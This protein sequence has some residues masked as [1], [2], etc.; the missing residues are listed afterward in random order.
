MR[1]QPAVNQAVVALR[2]HVKQSQQIFATRLGMSISTLQNH[3]QDTRPEPKQLLAFQREA[4]ASGRSDLAAR[5][6]HELVLS[7]ALNMEMDVFVTADAFE[8]QA[9]GMLLWAI[10][11]PLIPARAKLARALVKEIAA[12]LQADKPDEAEEFASEA[13]RRGFMSNP[14]QGEKK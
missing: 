5:F 9:V 13:V 11:A 3:E 8:T 7:L 4:E 1:E 6:Q 14:P 2:K 12:R 10:R